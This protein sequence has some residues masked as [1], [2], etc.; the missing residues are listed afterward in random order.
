MT[1]SLTKLIT[2]SLTMTTFAG[3][4]AFTAAPMAYAATW[5]K[6][7]PKVMQGTWKDKHNYKLTIAK[8]GIDY[9]GKAG[10]QKTNYRYLGHHKYQLRYVHLGN[11]FTVKA[12]THKMS[13]A[14]DVYKK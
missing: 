9:A 10:F 12:T 11:K 1:K 14:G 4:L 6:G 7:T 8:S 3:A 5:H 13:F 2:A